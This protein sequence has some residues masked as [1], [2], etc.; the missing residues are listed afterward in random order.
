MT[1][2]VEYAVDLTGA[3]TE[4][5]FAFPLTPAQLRMWQFQ[6]GRPGE[7][8][9]N[10]AFRIRLDGPV[11]VILLGET[12]ARIVQ[13]HEA[14]R[15]TFGLVD[16][17]LRQIIVP[18]VDVKLR[19]DDLRALEPATCSEEFDRISRSEAQLPFD[20]AHGPLLR[21]RLVQLQDQQYVLLLTLHQIV[22]DGYS[23]GLMMEELQQIYTALSLSREPVLTELPIQYGDYV[24][25]Q[26]QRMQNVESLAEIGYWKRSLQGYIPTTLI[27]DSSS[28]APD[29][30]S[31]RAAI[32]STLLPG[33]LIVGLKTLGN[34]HNATFFVTTLTAYLALLHY[35]TGE[36]DVTIG[37]PLAGRDLAEL[38]LL[39]GQF[40]NHVLIRT[41]IKPD[42]TLL[43]LLTQVRE[44]VWQ[45]LANQKL[46]FEIVL[47][48]LRDVSRD[49]S[50]A[51]FAANFVCQRE[52]GRA[53]KFSFEFA[54]IHMSTMPSV[55]QGALYDINFFL[56]EREVGWRLSLEYKTD[57]YNEATARGL[58]H[59]FQEILQALVQSP[60]ATLSQLVLS[61]EQIQARHD[62]SLSNLAQRPTQTS[63]PVESEYR[64][65]ASLAQKRFWMLSQLSSSGNHLPVRFRLAGKLNNG[66]LEKSLR[67]L[68][69]KHE[70]LRTTF[71]ENGDQLIQVVSGGSEFHL[72]VVDL[73]SLSTSE[74]ESRLDHLMHDEAHRPFDLRNGPLLRAKLFRISPE[75]HIFSLTVHHIA[76]DGW[77]MGVIGRDIWSFYE[78]I[79]D[80]HQGLEVS[81]S[82]DYP[83]FA[84][85]QNRWI[86][87]EEADSLRDYWKQVLYGE[88]PV[89]DFPTDRPYSRKMTSEAAIE[90]VLLPYELTNSIKQL[91]QAHQTTTFVFMLAC[92]SVM[93]SRSTSQE[94][95]VIGSPFANRSS[96]TDSIVGPLSGPVALRLNLSR[97]PSFLEFLIHVRDTVFQSL[98][99]ATL[100]FE[101]IMEQLSAGSVRG[102]NPLFQFY[103]FYQA[104]FLQQR[105]VKD[106]LV[107]PMSS[108][109]SGIPFEMQLGI[110]ERS[111]GLRAELQYDTHLF[112]SST[113]RGIL[114]YYV[115]LLLALTSNP[116]KMIRDLP[117]PP[118]RSP[119]AN[120]AIEVRTA[121]PARRAPRDTIEVKLV[122]I[123][124]SVLNQKG[125]GV[126]DNFFELGGGSLLVL[127]LIPRINQVFQ[128]LLPLPTI[129]IAPTIEML[130]DVI[131]QS[132]S[133]PRQ[134]I[135]P[136]QPA[137]TRPPLFMIHSYHLYRA[138]PA[139]LGVDQPFY[140][141]QELELVDREF[142]FHLESQIAA[143]VKQ[144]REVQPYGPYYLSGFCF[145]ANLA[146]EVAAQLEAAGEEV[147]LLALIDATCPHYWL[148]HFDSSSAREPVKVRVWKTRASV[149]QYHL[150][151]FGELP[152]A[153]KVPYITHW[154]IEKI[155]NQVLNFLLRFRTRAYGAFL[156]RNRLLPFFMKNKLM[157]TRVAV[158]RHRPKKI[159]ADI[160]LF[161]AQDEPMPHGFDTNFGW[162]A[163]TNGA[164]RTRW[165]TGDHDNMFLGENL[166]YMAA[167][168]RTAMDEIMESKK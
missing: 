144:I 94:D 124:E 143:Y 19:S 113:V 58:L 70:A 3:L 149:I 4:D 136:L 154:V 7:S 48:S 10:G 24:L 34:E 107:S 130:A 69:H 166:E 93:L 152:F 22:C 105:Q 12:F 140:G 30:S 167:Q 43:D 33:E 123:W 103:F 66:A 16:G 78:S 80:G 49:P 159:N 17:E 153:H 11:D 128:S 95:M 40:V 141:I 55:S 110:I 29:L 132:T 18:A 87:S 50:E 129:F 137:G 20:L 131:R 89:L 118:E 161:Q 86:E 41:K 100:P 27:P 62:L 158:R 142:P 97:S 26:L 61:D 51:P 71:Q 91:A 96:D 65:P 135:L 146:F 104:A 57:R 125:I 108:L 165:I 139:A 56:V 126:N 155:K 15:A 46:P 60:K 84:L 14:L 54:G 106:L 115:G 35:C 157:V 67:T 47:E 112:D 1:P 5:S 81:S 31:S 63:L 102:R 44:T 59:C 6:S 37:S 45:A 28:A 85:W 148:E 119:S 121:T 9:L 72:P 73:E 64:L 151:R 168:L 99:Q 133:K 116:E 109:P 42:I 75:T 76:A 164:V 163:A 145:F 32:I 38:E 147:G 25:W 127:R 98:A 88:L 74:R 114:E 82:I 122:E 111:E 21:I 68:I 117:G 162:S 8:L 150:K 52:Y 138:L 2:N 90:T 160:Y 77:S 120:N 83:D 134:V 101:V 53:D 39:V 92:F 23:I 13:R 36:Q 79:A 156:S